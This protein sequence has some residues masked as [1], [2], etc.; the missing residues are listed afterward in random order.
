MSS[1]Q[2]LVWNRVLPVR[3]ARSLRT[4]HVSSHF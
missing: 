1:L 4:T 3:Q 2:N